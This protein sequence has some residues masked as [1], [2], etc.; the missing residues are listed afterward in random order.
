MSNYA[1]WLG[2]FYD[3]Q[4]LLTGVFAL[5]AGGIAY[6]GAERQRASTERQTAHLQRG[7]K[8]ELAQKR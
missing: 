1:G 5:A 7:T 8:R 2:G 4:T 6:R 3:W